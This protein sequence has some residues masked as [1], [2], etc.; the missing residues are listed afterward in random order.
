MLWKG[1]DFPLLPK[2]LKPTLKRL[3]SEPSDATRNR[4]YDGVLFPQRATLDDVVIASAYQRVMS[5][6]ANADAYRVR[7][8]IVR[9]PPRM[10]HTTNPRKSSPCQLG[11]KSA[12]LVCSLKMSVGRSFQWA[13]PKPLSTTGTQVALHIKGQISPFDWPIYLLVRLLHG[14]QELNTLKKHVLARVAQLASVPT[15]ASYPHRSTS[16]GTSNTL[17][18]T[19]ACSPASGKSIPK[20]CECKRRGGTRPTSEQ[21]LWMWECEVCGGVVLKSATRHKPVLFSHFLGMIDT[22]P[23]S[24][25]CESAKDQHFMSRT[26]F[27]R[28]LTIK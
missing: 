27:V 24:V 22:R 9:C 1:T 25:H 10:C 2:A 4:Q 11:A 5:P 3:M 17:L 21:V 19:I 16:H 15:S 23:D 18:A 7:R 28:H 12:N 14:T 13:S 20:V 8:S 26:A 6:N